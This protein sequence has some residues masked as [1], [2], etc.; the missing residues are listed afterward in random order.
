MCCEL[1]MLIKKLRITELITPKTQNRI[2][3][4]TIPA[5]MILLNELI[6]ETIYIKY[7]AKIAILLCLVN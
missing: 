7:F 6:T 5:I 1:N 2:D 3:L 4:S